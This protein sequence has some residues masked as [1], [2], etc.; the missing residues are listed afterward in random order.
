MNVRELLREFDLHPRKKLGQNFLLAEG[1]LRKILAAAEVGPEDTVLEVGAGPGTL[2]RLLAERAGRVV[3]I[4][5]DSGLAKVLAHTLRA[6]HNVEIVEGDIL[7]LEPA[8]L[9]A[10]AAT[11]KVVANLPYYITSAAL[12]HL[13]EAEIRPRLMVVT[14]QYEVAQRLLARPGEMSLLAVSVQFYGRPK[15][16]ARVPAGAFYPR[17]EVDSAIVRID[18][19]P[20]LPLAVGD[21]V[22]FFTLVRAGFAQKRKQLRNSLAAGLALPALEMEAALRQAGIDPKRRPQSLSLEEWKRLYQA[23]QEARQL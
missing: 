18:L 12:R 4:E 2:T 1:I 16:V 17:P 3:A 15:L 23:L 20:A 22:R 13:L 7:A 21:L 11:Y 6:Y 14:V 19:H 5:L 8:R 10:P 9:V